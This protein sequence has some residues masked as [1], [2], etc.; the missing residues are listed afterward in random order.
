MMEPCIT[1][2]LALEETRP[3]T[4]VTTTKISM[5][6]HIGVSDF[7]QL[8]FLTPLNHFGYKHQTLY[9]NILDFIQIKRHKNTVILHSYYH[10]LNHSTSSATSLYIINHYQCILVLSICKFIIKK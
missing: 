9:S 10:I 7:I 3:V 8:V 1:I 4:L 6:M 2:L 5:A